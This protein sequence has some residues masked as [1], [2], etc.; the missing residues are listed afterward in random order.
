MG[1]ELLIVLA[2]RMKLALRDIDSLARL[3]GDEFV[4]V[5]VDLEAPED[6]EPVLRRLLISASEPITA[7]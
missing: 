4:A 3:G 1:D 2:Q 7:L 6:C 5:L